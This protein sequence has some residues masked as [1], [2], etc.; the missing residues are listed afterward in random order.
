MYYGHT[1]VEARK[2]QFS[3]N[4]CICELPKH[5]LPLI[6]SHIILSKN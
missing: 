1:Q 5:K 4:Y 2:S 3:G 6:L